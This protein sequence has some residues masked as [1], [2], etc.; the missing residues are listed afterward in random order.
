MILRW[1]E[2]FPLPTS[3]FLLYLCLFSRP[4]ILESCDFLRARKTHGFIF[5]TSCDLSEV[6]CTVCWGKV[7]AFLSQA[8]QVQ[9]T[10]SVCKKPVAPL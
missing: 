2:S 5:L 1:R 3:L 4:L 8:G 7:E 6:G 10:G 9:R